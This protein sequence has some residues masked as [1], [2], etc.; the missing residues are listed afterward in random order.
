MTR[1]E[2]GKTYRHNWIGDADLFDDWTVTK[3]TATTIT[4]NNGRETRVCRINKG[5]SEYNGCECV[6]PYGGYSMS[7]TLRAEK[8]VA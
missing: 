3:R 7:P 6:K 2:V 1:F 4:I 8:A 5:L